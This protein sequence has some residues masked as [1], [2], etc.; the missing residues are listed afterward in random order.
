[1]NGRTFSQILA[2]EEIATA[3]PL[4]TGLAQTFGFPFSIE[5]CRSE[6][7][8]GHRWLLTD[9]LDTP[10]AA[11]AAALEVGGAVGVVKATDVTGPDPTGLES[12]Q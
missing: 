3:T 10:S 7:R 5:G 12:V 1:M 11:H 6:P 4:G 8:S 2:S 9:R